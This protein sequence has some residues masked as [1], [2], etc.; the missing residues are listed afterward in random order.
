MGSVKQI[1]EKLFTELS[2]Q[3]VHSKGGICDE[4]GK[5]PL[6]LQNKENNSS[7]ADQRFYSDSSVSLASGRV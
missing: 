2:Q 3:N 4:I 7:C 1:N 5:L 6:L